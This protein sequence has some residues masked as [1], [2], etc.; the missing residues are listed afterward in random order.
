ME[1]VVSFKDG[2]KAIHR[3][4]LYTQ[5]GNSFYSVVTVNKTYRYNTDTI[6]WV[7]ENKM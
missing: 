1:V 2:E 4:V 3:A 6:S 7:S 5:Y